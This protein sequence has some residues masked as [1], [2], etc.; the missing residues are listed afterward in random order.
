VDVEFGRGH[1]LYGLSQ[2]I[3]STGEPGSPALPATGALVAVD[4]D[5]S[6]SVLANG[7]N[8]PTSLEFIGST[9]YVV[10]YG[11]EIW[12]IDGVPGPGNSGRH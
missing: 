3:F 12:R 5:G 11:G 4:E 8:Q 1:R 10:T 2:G 7:L 6:F 9:A